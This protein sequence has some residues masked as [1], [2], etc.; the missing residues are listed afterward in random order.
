MEF[1]GAE[2]RFREV[3]CTKSAQPLLEGLLEPFDLAAG[4]GVERSGPELGDVQLEEE[5]LEQHRLVT[6]RCV[7]GLSVVGQHR[8]R[9]TPFAGR[10]GDR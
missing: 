7:V 3:S 9:H 8:L 4:L 2:Q 1:R 5:V 6:G 10:G